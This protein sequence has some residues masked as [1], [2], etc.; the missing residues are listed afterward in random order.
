MESELAAIKRKIRALSNLGSHERS[1]EAEAM[2]AMK[3][4]GDLLLQYN[5][6]MDEVSLREEPCVTK[7]F[8]TQLKKRNVLWGCHD[9]LKKFCGV[10]MWFTRTNQGMHWSFFGLESD[11]DMAIYLSDFLTKVEKVAL[12]DFHN[13]AVYKNFTEHRNIISTNFK[14]AFADR[15][16]DRLYQLTRERETAEKEAAAYYEEQMKERMIEASEEALVKAANAKTGT[17]LIC[18]AKEKMIEEEFVKRG[19]KLVT[20]RSQSNARYNADARNAGHMAANNVNLSRPI[21][22]TKP[23]GYLK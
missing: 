23:N 17:A 6:T 16:N 18:L 11:V 21:S 22:N 10:K 13:S 5:L 7:S 1:N 20:H 12:L 2:L 4:V 8:N 9:G 3:K 14:I 15:L 19:P